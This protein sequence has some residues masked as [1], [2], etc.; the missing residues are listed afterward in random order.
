MDLTALA[1]FVNVVQNGSFTKAAVVM[2]SHKAQLSRTLAALERELG[3]KLLERTTRRITL[4][5]V[6]QEVFNQAV[7]ILAGVE[8]IRQTAEAQT[9]TPRGVLRITT[10]PEFGLGGLNRWISAYA[11]KYPD[12]RIEVD[13]TARKVDLRYEGVD[14]Y[15]QLGTPEETDTTLVRKL[16]EISYGLYASPQYLQKHG[17]PND[18]DQVSQHRLLMASGRGQK[19]GWRLVTLSR[20]LRVADQARLKANTS[21]MLRD[22]ALQGLGIALLPNV[23]TRD[24]VA[25]GALKR[26]LSAWSAPKEPVHAIM[27]KGRE[28]APKVQAFLSLAQEMAPA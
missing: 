1:T 10:S 25:R 7:G 13:L 28:S 8:D 2:R 14:V 18:G 15:L 12:V 6:G 27:P 26:V 4:T 21:A 3:I 22:A 9:G 20:E 24:D 19:S 23:M 16:G 17:T 11:E 5:S